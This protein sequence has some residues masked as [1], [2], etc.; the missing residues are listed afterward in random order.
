MR[1]RAT[2]VSPVE[3]HLVL[4]FRDVDIFTPGTEYLDS[5]LPEFVTDADR[6]HTLSLAVDSRAGPEP[7]FLLLFFHFSQAFRGQNVPCVYEPV[8]V[9]CVLVDFYKFFI[10][11]IV[12]VDWGCFGDHFHTFLLK[13]DFVSQSVE[14]ETVFNKF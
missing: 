5:A 9:G 4:G 3:I 13:F 6:D 12:F 14:I 8:Q 7:A 2:K 11:Q 10:A 1:K